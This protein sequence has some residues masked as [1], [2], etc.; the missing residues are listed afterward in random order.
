MIR[1]VD[2]WFSL[3]PD[4]VRGPTDDTPG[5]RADANWGMAVLGVERLRS[6]TRGK[7]ITV[8]VI[9]TGC[10][11]THPLLSNVID[12]R[13]FTG[14]TSGAADRNGHGTHTSSTICATDPGIGVAPE[15]SLVHGKGL[16]DGGSG[17]GG[18]IAN[19]M[20][21]CAGRG[22]VILSMSLGSSSEDGR[23]TE[24]ARQLSG[25][26]VWVVAAAGNSGP[27]T[28]DVDWPGRSPWCISVA[29]LDSQLRPASFSS[30]GAKIDTAGPGVGIWGAR[31]GGGLA[32]MSGTSMA[33]PFVAGLLAL[34]RAA[35]LAAGRGTPHVA[36]LR[37]LLTD[38]ST[39]TGDPGRDRRTGP[40]WAT[41]A[42]LALDAVPDPPRPTE[43]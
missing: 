12:A 15:C 32:Q 8:G 23:I 3:P 39:D 16:S 20:E 26:G 5:V 19:A 28:P 40:G 11:R 41:P 24:M 43:E 13:D 38:T 22:A 29:A 6:V 35:L 42:L 14:S 37:V 36:P 27:N 2:R 34:Y 9:D 7:G 18:W 30:A 10:D 25:D 31:P 17:A 21:W 4:L 33:T 1:E